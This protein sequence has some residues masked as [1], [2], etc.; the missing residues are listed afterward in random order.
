MFSKSLGAA[1]RVLGLKEI[2]MTT[3]IQK[4]INAAGIEEIRAFL[5]ENHKLDGARFDDAMLHAWARQAE[6]SLGDGNDAGI[7]LKEID[8]IFGRTQTFIVS[9]A[10]IDSCEVD[11][12]D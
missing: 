3:V 1:P 7:E 6:V 8:S 2:K 9:D 11:I 10:G 5:A 4:T 12:D